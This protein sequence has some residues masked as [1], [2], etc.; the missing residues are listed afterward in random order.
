MKVFWMFVHN[1]V[2]HP[3]M[4]IIELFTLGTYLPDWLEWLHEDTAKK[5]GF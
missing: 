3:A 2:I 5:A 1:C 4:G